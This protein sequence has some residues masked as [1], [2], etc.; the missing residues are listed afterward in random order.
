MQDGVFVECGAQASLESTETG[1]GRRDGMYSVR[2][3]ELYKVC[4]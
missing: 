2:Y 4:E 3:M 1:E